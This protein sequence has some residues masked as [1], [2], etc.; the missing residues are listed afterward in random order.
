MGSKGLLIAWEQLLILLPLI[1]LGAAPK[2][3][4]GDWH[5]TYI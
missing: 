4:R 2:Y 5:I 3:L 1:L